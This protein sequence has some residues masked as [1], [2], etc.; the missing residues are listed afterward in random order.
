MPTEITLDKAGR[1]LIPKTLR[2]RLHLQ[3]GDILEV[4]AQGEDLTIRP[5]R[6]NPS[7]VKEQGMWILSTGEAPT[8]SIL[9][10]IDRQREQRNR[11]VLGL[12]T[13]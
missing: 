10:L 11:H 1:I 12:D 2:E 5:Q 9:D 4:E 7:L 13:E 6:A 8:I 3:P